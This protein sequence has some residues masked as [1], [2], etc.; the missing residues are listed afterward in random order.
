MPQYYPFL[1]GERERLR[2]L[3][4]NLEDIP[5]HPVYSSALENAALD[6]EG[7]AKEPKDADFA[8]IEF[9]LAKVLLSSIDDPLASERYAERK[10]EGFRQSLDK[11]NLT[12]LI[13]IAREDFGMD[14]KTEESLRLQFID[15]LR[16]KPEFLKLAQMNL[17]GGYVQVTKSQLSWILKGAIK[18][19]TLKSIPK[20]EKFPEAIA[21]AATRVKGKVSEARKRIPRQRVSNLNE[22]ALPPCIVGIIKN[23]GAGTANHNAHFVL[24]TFLLGLGLD[25][26]SVL[27]VFKRSPK[28]KERIAAYQIKF[29]KDREYT[30]PACD[31]VKGYGLCPAT[32]EKNHP[33]SNYFTNLRKVRIQ[34]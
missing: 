8:V 22:E 14:V 16:Y 19:V 24:V 20:K 25:E 2:S 23:L 9:T 34:K 28:F 27:E 1:N 30:C 32:C 15:F 29:A 17:L 4:L 5:K 21:K 33:I 13:K 6:I 11:E 31:S 7:K 26:K 12:F 3:K 10:S 18:Q